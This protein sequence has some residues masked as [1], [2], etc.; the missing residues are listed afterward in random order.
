MGNE[1]KVYYSVRELDRATIKEIAEHSGLSRSTV[2]K[3]LYGLEKSRRVSKENMKP[4]T[5]WS[6]S[7]G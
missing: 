2:S 1:E 6:I 3:Y 7:E 4:Y 5:F